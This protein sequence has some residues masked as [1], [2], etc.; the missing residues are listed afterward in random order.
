MVEI[1]G[2][3]KAAGWN[4]VWTGE[5]HGCDAA[6][7]LGVGFNKT[8]MPNVVISKQPGETAPSAWPSPPVRDSK[9]L[10]HPARLWHAAA[11]QLSAVFLINVWVPV[12]N[13]RAPEGVQN[14]SCYVR[15]NS[16]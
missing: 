2:T 10:Q 4:S 8:R 12:R 6:I 1:L 15:G 16:A 3:Q 5:Q 14:L 7:L 11:I 13:S 9:D